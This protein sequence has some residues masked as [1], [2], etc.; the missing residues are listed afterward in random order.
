MCNK[1]LE[2]QSVITRPYYLPREITCVIFVS[3][4]VR[5]DGNQS[6]AIDTIVNTVHEL[7]RKHPDA[8]I[9]ILGDFN[10]ASLG[11]QLPLYTQ[12]VNCTTRL[13]KTL[14]L[15]YCNIKNAYKAL[16]KPPLGSSDHNMVYLAPTYRQRIKTVKPE[17]KIVECWSDD[18][19]DQLRGCFD[20][21]DWSVFTDS[22]DSIDE[23]VD[24]VSSY[25]NFCYTTLIPTKTVTLYP[26][27]KPWITKDLKE[28]ITTKHRYRM[29]GNAEDLKTL[30]KQLNKDIENCKMEYKRKIEGYLKSNNAKDAWKGLKNITGY[31]TKGSKLPSDDEEKLAS[32]LNYFYA[33]FEKDTSDN[34]PLLQPNPNSPSI[35]LSVENVRKTLKTVKAHKASGPDHIPCKVLKEC[36]G[37]L[38]PIFCELYNMSLETGT[39]PSLWKTATI[40][41]VPKKAK[42]EKM[43]DYRPVALTP[44]PMKRMEKLVLQK[45]RS[46]LKPL[47]YGHIPVRIH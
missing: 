41:P 33:R 2:L 45:I 42:I 11:K 17:K 40:V 38:A 5:C 47:T 19:L 21:T 14:D 34:I 39:V 4:Y 20:C 27:S 31:V 10:G 12:Y 8:A 35:V 26:N 30:Q 25:I 15:C 28:K 24:V 9:I 18:A 22:S 46:L 36:S 43:N 32:D 29:S 3:V 23:C 44:V 13:N 7:E 37:E 6:T 1:D 16:Q